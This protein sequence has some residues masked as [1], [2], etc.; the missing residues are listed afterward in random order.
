MANV[1][2]EVPGFPRY[3]VN[4]SGDLFDTETGKQKTWYKQKP[5]TELGGRKRNMKRGYLIARVIDDQGNKR[6]IFQHRV[7]AMLFI[8]C[9]GN[10]EDYI[11]NHKDGDGRNNDLDNLEWV[12]YSENMLH[13]YQTE[14]CKNTRQVLARRAADGKITEFRSIADCAREF[15]LPHP[16]LTNR[17]IHNAGNVFD[18]GFA[19]KFADDPKEWTDTRVK[20]IKPKHVFAIDLI[21][22]TF[23]MARDQKELARSTGVS[24][25]NINTSL[26]KG[27][28]L[29][30]NGFVFGWDGASNKSPHFTK[31]QI[32]LIKI[33]RSRADQTGWLETNIETGE[34]K[35]YL[36]SA[37]AEKF[38]LSMSQTN[39]VLKTGKSPCGCFRY[40]NISPYPNDHSP[41]AP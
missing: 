1:L 10:H 17:L 2:F 29:P 26:R 6:H 25:G 39:N 35:L 41:L 23:I 24:E 16:T 31:W 5:I 20:S 37:L 36:G 32:E 18:D 30:I 13:A 8:A 28:M 34:E 21:N 12:T 15:N 33:P 22:K 3:K 9:P 7:L 19:F 14:L 11:V 38:G 4:K 40:E 27:T